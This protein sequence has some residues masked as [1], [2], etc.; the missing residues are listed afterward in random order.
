MSQFVS[1]GSISTTRRLKSLFDLGVGMADAE[2]VENS[3]G[4][5]AKMLVILDWIYRFPDY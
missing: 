4:E 2:F 5:E 3:R 1:F